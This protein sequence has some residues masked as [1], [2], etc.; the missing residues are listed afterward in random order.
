MADQGVTG[1]FPNGIDPSIAVEIDRVN[2]AVSMFSRFEPGWGPRVG[3]LDA[4]ARKWYM[5]ARFRGLI[6]WRFRSIPLSIWEGELRRARE[7]SSRCE[8]EWHRAGKKAISR[9]VTEQCGEEPIQE[10]EIFGFRADVFSPSLNTVFEVGNTAFDKPFNIARHMGDER[11]VLS[12]FRADDMPHKLIEMV[13]TPKARVLADEMYLEYIHE[14]AER[15]QRA[16]EL[17]RATQER[18][19]T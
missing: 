7:W 15:R 6:A 5:E 12:P 18:M 4:L 17:R 19:R 9:V 13:I 10:C 16:M 2:R 3:N 1:R 11:F 14:I 8:T